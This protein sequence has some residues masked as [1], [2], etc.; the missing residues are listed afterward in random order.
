MLG[1]VSVIPCPKRKH[2]YLLETPDSSQ[3]S[4]TESDPAAQ[5]Q[6][7]A[8][9]STTA[10]KRTPPASSRNRSTKTECS[11]P[12]V[13]WSATT[14]RRTFGRN[15]VLARHAR[16]ETSFL[17]RLAAQ[18]RAQVLTRPEPLTFA[19]LQMHTSQTTASVAPTKSRSTSPS[20]VSRPTV[21]RADRLRDCNIHFNANVARP[22]ALARFLREHIT[23]AV[24]QQTPSSARIARRA[25]LAARKAEADGIKMLEPLV[26]GN[27]VWSDED[28]TVGYTE[29]ISNVNLRKEF[30]P[31]TVNVDRSTDFAQQAQPDTALGYIRLESARMCGVDAPFTKPEERVLQSR[32]ACGEVLFP[33]LTLQ[34]KSTAKGG[35]LHAAFQQ[36]ALDGATIVNSLEQLY[37][38][39]STTANND[40]PPDHV[41][42]CHFSFLSDMIS[43]QLFVHWRHI[44][45]DGEVCYEME[46]IAHALLCEADEVRKLRHA[47]KNIIAHAQTAR[48]EAIKAAARGLGVAPPLHSIGSAPFLSPPGTDVSLD[49]RPLTK[50]PRREISDE[51][52][53]GTQT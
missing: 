50:R 36:A 45:D 4:A 49:D 44:D 43:A 38:S 22:P 48:L 23:T 32:S 19:N 7:R 39:A 11:D 52:T 9:A 20:K 30:A 8:I 21:D 37:N 27:M 41:R 29:M 5:H 42:T 2:N 34:W 3:C 17:D 40:A 18:N 28:R 53:P 31:T 16:P 33:F 1:K 24:E 35:T 12:P 26:I 47:V 6:K 25:P 51:P 13:I 14:G 46:R 15:A 10:V